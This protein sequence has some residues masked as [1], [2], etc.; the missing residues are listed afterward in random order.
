MKIFKIKYLNFIII[1]LVFLNISKGLNSN[2]SS[3]IFTIKFYTY[4]I[5]IST[6]ITIKD[7]NPISIWSYNEIYSIIPFGKDKKLLYVLLSNNDYSFYLINGYGTFI[8]EYISNYS[9]IN[10]SVN[11]F[12]VYKGFRYASFVNKNFFISN[13]NNKEAYIENFEVVQVQREN[14]NKNYL[15]GITDI[16]PEYQEIYNIH[17]ITFGI[18][19]LELY[20]KYIYE[21]ADNFF[22]QLKKKKY[23]NNYFWSLKYDNSND[24]EGYLT[25]GDFPECYK[26]KQFYKEIKALPYKIGLEWDF[27]FNEIFF[28]SNKNNNKIIINDKTDETSNKINAVIDFNYG[29]ITSPINYYYYLIK[30]H[31][32]NFYLNNSICFENIT[33]T[34]N[35]FSQKYFY[36]DKILFTNKY[37]INFPPLFFY[38][39]GLNY[40][41]ELNYIDLFREEKNYI[42]F[43]IVFDEYY[44]VWTLGKIFIKKYKLYFNHDTKIIGF[45]NYLL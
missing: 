39:S 16:K 33:N 14:Q 31:F 9:F 5:N 23:I 13:K 27:L 8:S 18:L 25:I 35:Y 7:S 29:L 40:T 24:N 37:I 11:Y 30:E 3:N 44:K 4:N 12:F 42:Y 38:H 36:C 19:G 21:I 41:F 22:I 26:E 2:T 15:L 10:K 20:P 6:L 43:L 17:N 28:I 45:C 34:K 1:I 32:F